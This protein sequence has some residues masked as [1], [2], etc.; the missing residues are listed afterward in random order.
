M[1]DGADFDHPITIKI[2]SKKEILNLYGQA[3]FVEKKYHKRGFVQ[4]YLP[5]FGK[6]CLRPDGT[7]LNFL[8]SL[9][10]WYHVFV[11]KK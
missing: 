7:T 6:R 11:F 8:G 9:L 1:S 10:G 2:R 4:K 3:G 5:F